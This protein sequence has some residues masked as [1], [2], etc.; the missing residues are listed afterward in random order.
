MYNI[1]SDL[2]FWGDGLNFPQAITKILRPG[3]RAALLH[4]PRLINFL[5]ENIERKL[6]LV[7]AAAGYGK[8]SLLIDFAHETALPV[9][10]YS[11]DAS[12]ADP[13][14]FLE[15]IVASLCRVFPDF[16]A[17]TRDLLAVSSAAPRDLDVIVGSLVTEMVESIP[18]YFVLVLDDY[19]TIEESDPINQIVDALLRLL[20]ENA[21]LIIASRTLR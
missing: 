9:C 7:S 15:S 6:L 14:V 1:S 4:R 10:W 20:P 11:L 3:K 12:D 2:L 21:H 5:H 8:T 17:R 19:H 18:R 16:G 13:K